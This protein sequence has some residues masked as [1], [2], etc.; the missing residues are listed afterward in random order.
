MTLLIALFMGCTP[1]VETPN[2]PDVTSPVSSIE[3]VVEMDTVRLLTRMSL[4][5]RGVR[6]SASEIEAVEADPGQLDAF[7]DSF[8]SDPRFGPRIADLFAEVFHTRSEET[9]ADLKPFGFDY[10]DAELAGSVGH[11]PLEMLGYIAQN[12]LPYTDFVTADWTV[13]NEVLADIFNLEYP[14]DATGWQVARYQDDRPAAGAI[15]TNSLWWH[16]GSSASNM[17]RGR[18]NALTRIFLCFDHIE[19]SIDFDPNVVLTDEE[20]VAN[21]IRTNP[22]CVNCHVTLDP[23]ASHLFGFWWKNTHTASETTVYHQEREFEWM[24]YTEVPP[25]YF[26]QYSQGMSDLGQHIAADPRFPECMVERSWQ[27]LLRRDVEVYD[28]ELLGTHRNAFIDGGL[29]IRALFRSILQSP[30]YRADATEIEGYA[31]HKS[32]TPELLATSLEDLTGFEWSED[33]WNLLRANELGFLVLAG[34]ADGR[35]VKQ[36]AR[37]PNMTTSLVLERVAQASSDYAVRTDRSEPATARLFTKIDFTE[38]LE[39]NEAAVIE[40]IQH[41]HLRLFSRRVEADS[42]EVQSDLALWQELYDAE[43]GH[44]PQT[45]SG[46]LTVLLRDPDFMIY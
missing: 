39:N 4:D 3:D 22:S 38:N 17:N 42:A 9:F 43:G 31:S 35:E 24:N 13:A 15:I 44:I 36:S 40:Q 16:Y 29:T 2:A 34:G 27:L 12:D 26:G 45:W 33:D 7:T 20:A 32:L 8:L 10:S 14:D 41:L 46:L 5:L 28:A 25:S 11:E 19:R 21:A 30:E 1:I 23:I 6:P 37:E 18:A